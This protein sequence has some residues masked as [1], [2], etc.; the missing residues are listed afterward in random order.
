VNLAFLRGYKFSFESSSDHT[1]TH[2]S[3]AMV[4]SE[5]NSREDLLKAMRLRHTYGATDNIIADWRCAANGH[6]HMLGDE[7]KTSQPPTF[8]LKLHGTGPFSKVTIVRDDVEVN[9]TQPGTAEVEMT[10]TDP[11]PTEGKSSYYYV[12]G[13]QAD[14]ELVWVSPMWVTCLQGK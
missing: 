2:I 3:Y 9:V 13:E 6:E 8:R 12:R 14:G 5:S 4:Y 7:F 1:S 11:K 10:W